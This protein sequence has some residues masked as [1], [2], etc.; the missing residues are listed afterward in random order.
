MYLGRYAKL[1]LL[2]VGA[3]LASVLIFAVPAI[4]RTRTASSAGGRAAGGLVAPSSQTFGSINIPQYFT[5]PAGVHQVHLTAWG[6][7][8]GSGGSRSGL[9]AAPG[10]L[11]AE[12]NLDAPVSPGDRLVIQVGAKGGDA[13]GQSA[14][15]ASDSAGS[16]EGGGPGGT[17]IRAVTA[18]PAAGVVAARASWTHR[19]RRC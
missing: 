5:V 14:G 4:A 12:I 7:G 3:A 2:A 18:L 6:A 1:V 11:G 10:G 13:S 8:G 17:S 9:Y 15:F 19:V 16:G